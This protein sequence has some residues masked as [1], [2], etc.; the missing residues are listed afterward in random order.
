MPNSRSSFKGRRLASLCLGL[1]LLSQCHS[2]TAQDVSP[3]PAA[4]TRAPVNELVFEPK[5]RTSVLN[6]TEKGSR[7]LQLPLKIRLVDGHDPKVVA[8]TQIGTETNKVRL[9]A[10]GSGLTTMTVVDERGD[11]YK[12][13]ILVSGDVRHLEAVIRKIY[14][15]SSVRAE[16]IKDS[17]VLYGWVNQIDHLDKIVDIAKEYHASVINSL[18]V[19]GNQ[20][21]MLRVKIMEVQR[22]QIRSLGFNFLELTENGY[23]S[24]T[25][26]TLTPLNSV[27]VPFGGPPGAIMNPT[28][29]ATATFGVVS[30]N[31]IFQGFIEALKQ[32]ALLKILAEPN[33]M[34][35]NGRPSNFLSGGEF[36]ILVPQGLGTVSVQFRP[37]GVRLEFVP[38]I[39]GNNRVRLDVTPEVSDRDFTNQVALNGIVVPSLTVRRANAQ[40]EMNFGETLIIAGLISNRIQSRTQKTP[41]LGDLPWIGAAFRRVTHDE[42]ETEL[43]I[44]VTPEL[45]GPM[46]DDQ[47]PMGPGYDTVS[48]TD[49][50]LYGKGYLEVPRV[51]PDPDGYSAG[52]SIQGGY[53]GDYGG[54]Y[55]DPGYGTTT[56]SPSMAPDQGTGL[57]PPV[58]TEPYFESRPPAP[59]SPVPP[60][61]PVAPEPVRPTAAR[62]PTQRVQPVSASRPAQKT[63]LRPGQKK[64]GMIPPGEGQRT[65][66]T[67]GANGRPGLIK[68]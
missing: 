25:P 44:M 41:F 36:P 13:E 61:D 47:L 21:V 56:P 65:T 29:S 38:N 22:G 50:E 10:V 26:G 39:L 1:L 55:Q 2:A 59:A 49:G 15:D 60:P 11:S 9:T 18:R 31:N 54:G 45:G 24:S 32:E 23:A 64:P 33:L 14:P 46:S 5:E 6:L 67:R 48:P 12:I 66:T 52:M 57:P 63:T 35:V 4:S 68:P 51:A 19:S 42:A 7:I 17:V 53:P 20:Q 3:E 40:V 37:F 62:R 58:P 43:M 8:V 28:A 16:K 30:N 34:A 27:T